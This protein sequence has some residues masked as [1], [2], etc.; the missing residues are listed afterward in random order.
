MEKLIL[1]KFASYI[2]EASSL[3]NE[4]TLEVDLSLEHQTKVERE[5]V[6]KKKKKKKKR[7]KRR[8]RERSLSNNGVLGQVFP[9]ICNFQRPIEILLHVSND[10]KK[11]TFFK[12]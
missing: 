5:P 1:R 11:M 4:E 9:L 10:P 6:K 7:R 3:K 2:E 12:S 8:R